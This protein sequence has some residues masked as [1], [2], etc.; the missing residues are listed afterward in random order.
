M[1]Q[2][3]V[4]HQDQQQLNFFSRRTVSNKDAA[5]KQ[6]SGASHLQIS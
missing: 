2:Q 4:G 1:Q 3:S 5:L 6:A